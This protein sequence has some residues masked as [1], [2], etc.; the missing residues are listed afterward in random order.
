MAVNNVFN[1]MINNFG[2]MRSKK[3]GS[4]T[5]IQRIGKRQE[6]THIMS[7]AKSFTGNISD[8]T[9]NDYIGLRMRKIR[10]MV[11][12]ARY[13]G[14]DVMVNKVLLVISKQKVNEVPLSRFKLEEERRRRREGV[15]ARIDF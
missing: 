5:A 9:A 7:P 13:L 15:N 4:K 2:N 14:G 3:K 8:I 10:E 12:L 1:D 6:R 11:R